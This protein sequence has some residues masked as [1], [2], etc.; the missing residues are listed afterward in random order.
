MEVIEQVTAVAI[1]LLLLL[2]DVVV[3]APPR[4][5]RRPR[6]RGAAVAAAW[7][8]G[9]AATRAAART[10]PGPARGHRTAGGRIAQAAAPC[11]I[12]RSG[13]TCRGGAVRRLWMLMVAALPGRA[14]GV[15]ARR[16]RRISRY[17]CSAF[18][19][20]NGTSLSVPMQIVILLTLMT[21]LPAAVMSITPFPAHRGRAAFPAAGARHA[22][23]AVQPGAARAGAVSGADH[24]AAGDRGHVPPGL[25]A[26]GSR[27]DHH[28][29]RRS[30]RAPNRSASSWCASRARRTFDSVRRALAIARAAHPGRS[31]PAGF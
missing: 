15:A 27:P 28:P 20:R 16:L 6:C 8:S 31:R 3:A 14:A 30:T 19:P 23:H 29:S 24:H 11:C 2:A 1:V 26:H 10:A 9:A 21:L 5:G 17:P 22:V 18:P 4:V 25:G 13:S 12:A 7:R